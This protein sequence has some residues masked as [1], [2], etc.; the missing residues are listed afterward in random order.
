MGLCL[1]AAESGGVVTLTLVDPVPSDLAS[2]AFYLPSGPEGI[3]A[4]S[5]WQGSIFAITPTDGGLLAVAIIAVWVV[6]WGVRQY[7]R[8]LNN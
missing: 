8:A 1:T 5:W 2:C 6:G 7:I 3:A 4:A